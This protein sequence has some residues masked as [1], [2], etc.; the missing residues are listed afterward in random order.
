M[1]ARRGMLLGLGVDISDLPPEELD[2]P[3]TLAGTPAWQ[4]ISLSVHTETT[5]I[6]V[7]SFGDVDE[8]YVPTV[9]RRSVTLEV[10][11]T[12]QDLAARAIKPAEIG[13]LPEI[14]IDETIGSLRVHGTLGVRD[15]E[16]SYQALDRTVR[17]RFE[18]VELYGQE[19]LIEPIAAAPAPVATGRR[20]M[21]L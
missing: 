13:A 20:G 8:I 14:R 5:Q 12:E 4:V 7:T 2:K 3:I 9:S 10:M 18:C 16:W 19:L 17:A 6:E 11:A 21:A 1:S 15:C